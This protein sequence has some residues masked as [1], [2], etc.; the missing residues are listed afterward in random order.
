MYIYYSNHCNKSKELLNFLYKSPF[1]NK[2][3]YVNI[4]NRVKENNQIFILLNNGQKFPLPSQIRNVPTLLNSESGEIYVGDQIK[5][6]LV[7]SHKKI[8]RQIQQINEDPDAF[9]FGSNSG[10]GNAFGVMSDSFS[11]LNQSESEMK[12]DG[13]GGTR[14]M[15]NYVSLNN[16]NQTI[17]TPQD[18]DNNEGSG[19]M[20]NINLEQLEHQRNQDLQKIN[21]NQNMVI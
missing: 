3:K 10:G 20:K 19:R 13:S 18:D 2:F 6:F 16:Y 4:D 21:S 12:A 11:F 15:Y 14:Q 9:T 8:Q 17:D 1:R 7:P 5:E